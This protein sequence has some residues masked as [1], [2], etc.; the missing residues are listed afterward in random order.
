MPATKS[1]SGSHNPVIKRTSSNLGHGSGRGHARRRVTGLALEEEPQEPTGPTPLERWRLKACAVRWLCFVC[2]SYMK[3][4]SQNALKG[5]LLEVVEEILTSAESEAKRTGNDGIL[6]KGI[7]SSAYPDMTFD[8][9]EFKKFSKEDGGI[10]PR[11]KELLVLSEDDRT[12]EQVQNIVRCMQNMEEFAKY[13]PVIQKSMCKYA[14]YDRYGRNRVVIKEGQE[15]DGLYIIISGKLTETC[16]GQT[17]ILTAGDKFGETDLIRS[18]KRTSTVMTKDVVEVFCLHAEDYHEVFNTKMSD[19]PESCIRYLRTI[20]VFKVWPGLGKLLDYPVNWTIQNYRPGQVIVPNS[21][22][23]DWIVAIKSGKCDVL[24]K[25]MPGVCPK[26]P[27]NKNYKEFKKAQGANEMKKVH[28]TN[29]D[30]TLVVKKPIFMTST[31]SSRSGGS[32][33]KSAYQPI[34]GGQMKRQPISNIPESVLERKQNLQP[35]MWTDSLEKKPRKLLETYGT[36][37]CM[38][39]GSELDVPYCVRVAELVAGD[40]FGMLTIL[41][42]FK[43]ASVSLVSRG[44]EAVRINKAFFLKYADERVFTQIEM[45]YEAF[46]TQEEC[47]TDLDLTDQWESYK[48]HEL[49]KTVTQVEDMAIHASMNKVVSPR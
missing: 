35:G 19:T 41:P 15:A 40:V 32:R 49:K 37:G 18:S 10:P 21:N 44:A 6:V 33:S 43:E 27:G 38:K 5:T 47:L 11:I 34:S 8:V 28:E 13:P 1:D 22:K 45:R 16:A 39:R 2:R 12:P 17:Y 20:Q 7:I 25:L 30:M 36:N 46:P 42:N 3:Q 4:A 31:P 26:E 48:S 23:N 24:K 9:G 29:K 14:W